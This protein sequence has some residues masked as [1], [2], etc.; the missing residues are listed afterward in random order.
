MASLKDIKQHIIAVKKTQ[1][2]TRAM[3]MVAAAKLR[4]VQSRTEHFRQYAAKHAELIGHLSQSASIRE[5]RLLRQPGEV[6]KV[7]V[8]AFSS[9][10]GMCGSFNSNAINLLNRNLAAFEKE[11]LSP[12]VYLVGRKLKDYYQRIEVHIPEAFVGVMNS[13]DYLLAQTLADKM[14]AAFTA[15]EYGRIYLLFTKF[16]NVASQTPVI[17]QFLPISC[18]QI[19]GLGAAACDRAEGP[20][21]AGKTE[22]A[23]GSSIYDYIVEP[24]PQKLLTELMPRSLAIIVYQAMLET[25]TSEHAARMQA[26]DNATRNCKDMIDQ[27]SIAYNKARQAAVTAELLDIVGGVEA[28]SAS[29]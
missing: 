8:L 14:I 11:G 12:S 15:G 23:P 22:R 9:D 4:G 20:E 29:S 7:A 16:N 13:F 28:L 2:L 18:G 5:S 1:K 26:M 24:S 21:A 10:R 25:V 27:L 6:K 3:N 19:E 17:K